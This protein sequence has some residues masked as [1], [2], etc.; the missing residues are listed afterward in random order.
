M[1]I[2]DL[3]RLTGLPA[4]EGPPDVAEISL[5][6][7]G[8]QLVALENAAQARGV[9]SAQLVRRL[10]R[11]FINRQEDGELEPDEKLNAACQ[12]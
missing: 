8:W 3:S 7:P 12:W 2:P 11:E 9:T 1:S 10:L 6:L 5:L 4:S